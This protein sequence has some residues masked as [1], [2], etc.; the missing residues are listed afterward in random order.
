MVTTNENKDINIC[1]PNLE[2]VTYGDTKDHCHLVCT[3]SNTVLSNDTIINLCI[4]N[5]FN[6]CVNL[7]E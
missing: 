2:V 5:N 4:G 7:L 6:N 1:C 3:F